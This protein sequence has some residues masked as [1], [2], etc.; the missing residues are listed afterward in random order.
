MAR[1]RK[2]ESSDVQIESGLVRMAKDGE[3][4]DVHPSCVKAHEQI[5]WRIVPVD[6]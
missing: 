5:G 4:I 3:T 6:V 2:Q 1:P